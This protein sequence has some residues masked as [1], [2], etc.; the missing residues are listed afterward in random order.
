MC[1][2]TSGR[3]TRWIMQLQE[4]DLTVTHISGAHNFFADALCRN[5]T[6][7]NN[8][9]QDILKRPKEFL[10]AKLDLYKDQTLR[11]ELSS[12]EQHQLEVSVLFII[13]E[14]LENDLSKFQEKY[15]IRDEV[16]HC[17]DKRTYPYRRMMLPRSLEYQVIKYMHNLLGHQDTSKCMYHIS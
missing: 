8:E 5:P 9:K 12:L 2:L 11:K 16:L 10:V 14:E 4:Y 17:K 1:N 3:V 15:M 7:L 6:G 13:R